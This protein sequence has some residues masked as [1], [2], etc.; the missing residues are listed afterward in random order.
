MMQVHLGAIFMPHGLGHFIGMDVH[1]V[2]GYLDGCPPRDASNPS[3]RGLR[4]AKALKE[5]MMLTI[6]PGCYFIDSLLDSAIAD[7]EKGKFIVKNAIERFRGFGGIRIEDDVLITASGVEDF[8]KVPR[9]VEDIENLMTEGR[10]T[11]VTFP[12]QKGLHPSQA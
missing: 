2:G 10:K 8:T 9:T 11:E 5:N 7:N 12:Q 4:T 6:E 3:L 1:D